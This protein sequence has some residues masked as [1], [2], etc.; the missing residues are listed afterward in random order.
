MSAALV[1][2]EGPWRPWMDT[3]AS[4]ESSR[5]LVFYDI[6]PI[7]TTQLVVKG[8]GGTDNYKLNC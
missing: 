3:F 5:E 4:A 2:G 7:S 6:L 8:V 1:H